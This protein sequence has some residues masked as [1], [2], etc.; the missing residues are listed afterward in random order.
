MIRRWWHSPGNAG[1]GLGFTNA[2]PRGNR[3]TWRGR[4]RVSEFVK[5]PFWWGGN[6]VRA[7]CIRIENGIHSRRGMRWIRETG[8]V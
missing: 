5:Y 2:P 1:E 4:I 3:K 7:S 6:N 8:A